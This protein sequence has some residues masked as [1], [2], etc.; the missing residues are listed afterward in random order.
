MPYL[1]FWTWTLGAIT[2]QYH[3]VFDDEFKTVLSTDSSQ[4][5]F[6]HDDW[7][8]TFG[9]HPWQYIP[10]ED[11]SPT[12]TPGITQSEGAESEGARQLETRRHILRLSHL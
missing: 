6:E 7:Y 5:N 2:P 1:E 11:I 12:T 8:K 4:V 10:D 9:L 3:V